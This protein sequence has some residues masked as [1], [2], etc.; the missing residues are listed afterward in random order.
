MSTISILI[1]QLKKADDLSIDSL[2][3]IIGQHLPSREEIL[4]AAKEELPYGRTMLYLDDRLEVIIGC[5][6]RGGWCDVH[7][8]GAAEGIVVSYNGE[9]EHFS[10][11]FNNGLLDLIEHQ[12][13]RENEL[14]HLD[15]GMIHSLQNISSDEPYIG[16]HIYSPPTSDVRIFDVKSGDIYHVT[17]DFPALIPTE[18]HYITRHEKGKFTFRNL[19]RAKISE[20]RPVIHN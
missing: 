15:I 18:E 1:E 13:M 20:E 6:P 5:W 19:V 4:S 16:L 9:I 7:D 10:Y 12:T 2:E 8:H 14:M 17:D 3:R 11:V